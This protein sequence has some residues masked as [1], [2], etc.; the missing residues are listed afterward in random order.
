MS[1]CKSLRHA[2]LM[3]NVAVQACAGRP[4]WGNLADFRREFAFA[5]GKPPIVAEIG[6]SR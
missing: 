3:Q 4:G 6:S 1:T 2:T 5:G